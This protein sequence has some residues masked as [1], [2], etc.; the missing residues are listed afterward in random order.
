MKNMLIMMLVLASLSV[1][2]QKKVTIDK[3][4]KDTVATMPA[5][6]VKHEVFWSMS[7]KPYEINSADYL[8]LQWTTVSIKSIYKDHAMSF[9][10]ADGSVVKV[11]P[12]K[13]KVSDYVTAD[14]TTWSMSLLYYLPKED[15]E[16]LKA[17]L[18][19]HVRVM[20]VDGYTEKKMKAKRAKKLLAKLKLM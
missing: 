2:A 9:L 20:T 3:F 11:Y 5:V 1:Q 18:V 14:P 6:L 10:M 17:S 16:K 4:S 12:I 13:G 8:K 19:T 15:K 7:L